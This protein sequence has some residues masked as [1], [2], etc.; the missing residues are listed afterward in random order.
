MANVKREFERHTI[1]RSSHD[2]LVGPEFE[3]RLRREC[4]SVSS[5]A[6]TGAFEIGA[7]PIRQ[8]LADQ[9]VADKNVEAYRRFRMLGVLRPALDRPRTDASM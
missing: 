3:A 4:K 8:H 2:H 5:T 7:I 6:E 1:K 9:R